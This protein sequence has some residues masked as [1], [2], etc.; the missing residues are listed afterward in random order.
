M[1]QIGFAAG[2][3]FLLNCIL[4]PLIIR[5]ASKKGLY[6]KIDE[7]KIHTG[8][9]P[10]LGGV[11]FFSSF[12]VV[13]LISVFFVSPRF[14]TESSYFYALILIALFSF[15]V[16]FADDLRDLR[17]RVK[18]LVQIGIA[19]CILIFG[20]SFQSIRVPFIENPVSLGLTGPLITFFWIVGVMNAVNLIDGMDGLAG[21]TSFIAILFYLI[22]AVVSKLDPVIIL[23][24]AVFE[25]A[26]GAFLLF[27]L[28]PA[29]IF[30]GDGGSLL[31]GAVLSFLP[32]AF[33]S[34]GHFDLNGFGLYLGI[35]LCAVPILDTLSAIIRRLVIKRVHF[36]TPDKEHIHHKLLGLGLKTRGVLAVVYSATIGCGFFVLYLYASKSTLS[37]TLLFLYALCLISLLLL[38][39]KVHSCRIKR[40]E[41]P[42][43]F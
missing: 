5:F 11:G 35:A 40:V 24:L 36:F 20:Y 42:K 8:Q 28:P 7:R 25:G 21:G 12:L 31:L 3:A 38:L 16:G 33:D 19:F 43:E 23:S 39:S 13:F 30:M 32:L 2:T 14:Y 15:A 29:K 18:F 10:R 41:T 26:L 6:D 1:I 17:A 9:I 34:Q 37:W 4:T 27:N 22:I